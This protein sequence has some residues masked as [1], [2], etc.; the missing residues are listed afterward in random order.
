MPACSAASHHVLPS[1]PPAPVTRRLIGV[2]LGPQLHRRP[3]KTQRLALERR[4][5]PTGAPA[6]SAG[7]VCRSMRRGI[8]AALA[9]SLVCTATADAAKRPTVTVERS[10]HGVP[11]IEAKNFEGVAYGYGYAFAE[12]NICVIAD[13]YV[14]VS[15][16]RSTLLRPRR[17]YVFRGNGRAQQPELRLLLPADQRDKTIEKLVA[18]APAGPVPADQG[19]GAA[20]CAATT[21]T[22]RTRRRQ[23]TDPNC[24]GEK[25]VHRSPRRPCRRFYQLALLASQGVA[26][27]GIGTPSRPRPT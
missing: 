15:A 22:S 8:V 24:R 18:Q 14:T 16:E 7:I 21:S 25:W 2:T 1:I 12:D 10:A 26:I 6:P 20:T 27:N 11:N 5:D 9:A 17:S 13:S 4:R 19:R 23:I 3:P